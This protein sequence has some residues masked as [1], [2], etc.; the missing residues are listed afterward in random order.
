MH[1]N[2]DMS[3]PEYLTPP[4]VSAL[5]GVGHDKILAWVHSGELRAVDLSATRGKRPRWRIS[6]DDLDVFLACRSATTPPKTRQRRRQPD[7]VTTF[8]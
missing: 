3:K 6:R 2:H 7:N 1:A 4:Q 5:L 8:Y